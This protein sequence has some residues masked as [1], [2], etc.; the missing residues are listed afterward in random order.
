MGNCNSRFSKKKFIE[1]TLYK[2]NRNNVRFYDYENRVELGRD[3]VVKTLEG[4]YDRQP[5]SYFK[6]FPIKPKT[7]ELFI[8]NWWRY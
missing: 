4:I 7:L 5:P 1:E 3:D 2:L 6:N 8:P